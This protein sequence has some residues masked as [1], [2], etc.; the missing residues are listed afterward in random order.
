ML[1]KINDVKPKGFIL[2]NLAFFIFCLRPPGMSA[3]V[4]ILTAIALL[5]L[6][7]NKLIVK[8]E[9]Q[10]NLLYILI[11][12]MMI[13]CLVGFAFNGGYEERYFPVLLLFSCVLIIH[14]LTA[15]QIN[16]K[17]CYAGFYYAIIVT[18]ALV[19]F[20]II[21]GY[22]LP[23]SRYSDPTNDAQ[24]WSISKPTAFYYNEN[25]MLSFLVCF[26]PF[27][28]YHSKK[29]LHKIIIFLITLASAVYIGSKAAILALLIYV[30]FTKLV[31]KKIILFL[32]ASASLLLLLLNPS[33]IEDLT[34]LSNNAVSR[35]VNFWNTLSTTGADD[36]ST[37][38]RLQIYKANIDWLMNH[39]NAFLFGNG[40]FGDYEVD[41]INQYGLRMGEFH[42]IH[43]EMIT[44]YGIVF[45]IL[46]FSYYVFL[47]WK[48]IKLRYIK[49]AVRPLITSA[50]LYPILISFGPSSS[51][52]YPFLFIIVLL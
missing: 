30:L 25:D 1:N 36:E 51:L 8:Y 26:L 40:R 13:R 41:I 21:T 11:F 9:R 32:G 39:A 23:S 6:F 42:N 46:F 4:F 47:I 7:S 43:F 24:L 12:I 45:Y 44:I 2:L 22:H 38:E 16:L 37:S 34:L 27:A 49:P 35:L 18:L 29:N 14:I 50:I 52:K 17:E 31:S 48:C 15:R 33:I 10:Y 19:V 3:I 20:E 28:I 5:S